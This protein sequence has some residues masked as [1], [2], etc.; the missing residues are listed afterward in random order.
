ML[1][2]WKIAIRPRSGRREAGR[3]PRAY[4]S[5]NKRGEIAMN[6]EAWARIRSPWNVT[7]L[8]DPTTRR[9]GIK[10]PITTDEYYFPVCTYGRDGKMRIVRAAKMLEQFGIR[11]DQTLIFKHCETQNLNRHPMLVLSLNAE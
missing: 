2:D 4:V 9:I 7:L 11:I 6:A 1:D 3:E 10:F 8:Y 5:I